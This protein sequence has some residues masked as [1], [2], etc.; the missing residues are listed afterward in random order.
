MILIGHR[1]VAALTPENTLPSIDRALELGLSMIEIDVRFAKHHLYVLHDAKL[2]RTTNRTGSLLKLPFA[3][4]RAADAGNGTPIPLLHEVIERIDRRAV[5]NIELKGGRVARPVVALL[6]EFLERGWQ[7]DD[8]LISSFALG[9]LAAAKKAAPHFPRGLLVG[10]R[11]I[12]IVRNARQLQVRTV[13][14]SRKKA[15]P[16]NIDACRAAGWKVFVYTVNDRAEAERLQAM[17]VD[18]IFTDDP[19]LVA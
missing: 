10:A 2:D 4:V 6:D 13:H 8:F 7:P 1:G 3:T 18:G 19:G 17:G 14:L 9:E 15:I 5:L 12:A 11:P 16:A